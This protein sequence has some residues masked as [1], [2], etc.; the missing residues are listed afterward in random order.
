MEDI[1][2]TI[3]GTLGILG[4]NNQTVEAVEVDLDKPEWTRGTF[5]DFTNQFLFQSATRIA[6]TIS[7][8]WF[9]KAPLLV[10]CLLI[11][12]ELMHYKNAIFVKH[13]LNIT[14]GIHKIY[15]D[16][17]VNMFV[18]TFSNVTWKLLKNMILGCATRSTTIPRGQF[19]L[20]SLRLDVP[21]VRFPMPPRCFKLVYAY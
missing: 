5:Q 8:H 7:F 20:G 15:A 2:Y 4:R 14:N 11:G 12:L 1:I 3:R 21:R 17:T 16:K 9:A 18:T 10:Q 6:Q 19:A 13:F